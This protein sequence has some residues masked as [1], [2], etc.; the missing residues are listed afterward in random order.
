MALAKKCDRC[1]K[2]YEYYPAGNKT[3]YNAVKR[4]MILRDGNLYTVKNLLI[5]VRNA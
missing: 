1:G 3:Q 2:L 4:C 5:Y